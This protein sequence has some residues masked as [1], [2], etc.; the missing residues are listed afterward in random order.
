MLSK[1][2]ETK[3]S[4]QPS[5]RKPQQAAR[6]GGAAE[7]MIDERG[8]IDRVGD[9]RRAKRALQ[10]FRRRRF[11]PR[12][13]RQIEMRKHGGICRCGVLQATQAFQHQTALNRRQRRGKIVA[14]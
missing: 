3:R 5:S 4:W 10:F 13:R 1:L 9:P 6:F 7:A 12:R 2:D 11:G 14:A 8:A